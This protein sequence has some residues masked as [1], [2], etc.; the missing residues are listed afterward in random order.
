VAGAADGMTLAG[1]PGALRNCPT[2]PIQA[3][4]LADIVRRHI[5]VHPEA[6]S[7]LAAEVV[8][9]ALSEAYPCSRGEQR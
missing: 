4:E 1:R 7:R 6:R 2:E 9:Q 3:R 5:A 8:A